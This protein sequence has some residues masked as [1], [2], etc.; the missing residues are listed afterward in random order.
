MLCFTI[1]MYLNFIF[2][3]AKLLKCSGIC[4]LSKFFDSKANSL[5]CEHVILLA[6]AF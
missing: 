1:Y 5:V 2:N 3:L 4:L 6:K